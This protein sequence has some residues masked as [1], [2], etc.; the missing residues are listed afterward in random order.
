MRSRLRLCIAAAVL[1]FG[2]AGT[3]SLGVEAPSASERELERINKEMQEKKDEIDRVHKRERSVLSDLDALDRRLH[4]DR[5][6]LALQK[7]K[8]R[9]A[10]QALKR[11]EEG[12]IDT[13]RTLVA[14]KRQYALRLR[15]LYKTGRDLSPWSS[16]GPARM[17]YLRAIAERDAAVIREYGSAL[18]R[19]SARYDE[20][21]AQQR[22]ILERQKNVAR[23]QGEL[24]KQK[25]QKA[26]LLT[27]VREEK[28]VYEQTL[29]ELEESSASLWGM[30][31]KDEQARG[32]NTVRT[33]PQTPPQAEQAPDGAYVW[34][35]RGRIL[36]H[37]GMQKHPQFGT[38]IFRRG[39]EIEAKEGQPVRAMDAGRVRY[40][41]W[42]KGYGDLVIVE[43]A[44]GLY[45][46]YGNL[47][48][49]N[50]KKDDFV[51]K[52]AVVGQ[53][54]ETN[55]VKGAKLYFEVRRN[56]KAQDPMRWLAQR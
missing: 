10:E 45:S 46:L 24:R 51:E 52:G 9:E 27:S 42:Y 8:L 3:P 37:F 54:G 13:S 53:A 26:E 33:E 2:A 30:I 15:A 29:R 49:L 31:R 1:A 4:A 28:G 20:I 36:T 32:G 48:S 39:I 47:A 43:H 18:Q 34:P 41:D 40:A 16:A 50:V 19:F 7:K 11:V 38:M 56:G 35:V 12:S 44:N 22:E 14:C 6:D 55:S 17:R 25:H 5:S 21:A 23:R